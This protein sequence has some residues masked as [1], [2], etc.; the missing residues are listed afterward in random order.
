MRVKR[1][2]IQPLPNHVR[3]GKISKG[4]NIVQYNPS[5][6]QQLDSPMGVPV[7]GVLLGGR[8]SVGSSSFVLLAY[9][10]SKIPPSGAALW[11]WTSRY[12]FVRMPC[13]NQFTRTLRCVPNGIFVYT[14]RQAVWSVN[15]SFS[16][17][18]GVLVCSLLYCCAT[19]VPEGGFAQYPRAKKAKPDEPGV[20]GRTQQCVPEGGEYRLVHRPFWG[21]KST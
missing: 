12:G 19:T 17:A 4:A 16:L 14:L 15:A 1:L 21:R 9:G 10:Y 20:G 7:G 8:L 6:P 11:G 5:P 18:A 13:G 3:G 2:Q